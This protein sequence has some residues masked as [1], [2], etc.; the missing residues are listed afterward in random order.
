MSGF[1]GNISFSERI[2]PV[3]SVVVGDLAYD[4]CGRTADYGHRR[5]VFRD[6][7]VGSNYRA[8]SNRDAFE[9]SG[10]RAD[11]DVI[12][13]RD[14]SRDHG[15]AV[16]GGSGFRM[17]RM[18]GGNYSNIRSYDNIIPDRN[19][20]GVEDDQIVIGVEVLA[21]KDLFSVIA[22]ER[23]LD[24]CDF[25]HGTEQF[26]QYIVF[27]LYVCTVDG[28]VFLQ[29]DPVLFRKISPRS[30]IASEKL[31][32]VHLISFRLFQESE[33]VLK[34]VEPVRYQ[35]GMGRHE[36][37]AG[38]AEDYHQDPDYDHCS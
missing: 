20:I 32:C 9:Y 34:R 16:T 21:E 6:Q 24:D 17:Y 18:I 33:E 23:R 35:Y 22:S 36:Q 19:G 7:R 31:F 28:I 30:G 13:Y 26:F 37:I 38:D 1:F 2:S 5:N 10:T 12:L 27:A 4:F 11:P 8:V 29:K 15:K 3:I 14:R 25:V